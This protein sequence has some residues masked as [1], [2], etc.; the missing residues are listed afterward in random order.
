MFAFMVYGIGG[1][2]REGYRCMLKTWTGQTE[3]KNDDT[4][5]FAARI[6]TLGV[7]DKDS[8]VTVKGAFAN[9]NTVR[10]S[11]FNHSSAVRDDLPVGVATIREEG[12]A[13]IAEGK[14]NLQSAGGRELYDTLKFEQQHNV[15]SEWS[16]GFT[17]L[18]AESEQRDD[19]KVRVLKK[20]NPFEV[21]PVMRGAG[22]G[23]ATLAVKEEKTATDF[24]DLPL[25]DR[26][27]RWNSGAALKRVRQW[28]SKDGSGD[29][30]AM[31][32]EKY[33]KAFFWY[34]PEDDSSFGGFKLPFA[35]IT[36]GK[37]YA[38]PRG[39]F[40]VAGVLQG[41]RGG[42][43]ISP[44]DQDHV[45]DTVDRYYE[46]MRKEFDDDSIMVPWSKQAEGLSLK[47][48]G[49]LALT[50]IDSLQTRINQ[51]A[52]LRVKE[53][54]TLSS[55]NRKRLGSL[56]QS[57]VGVVDDLSDLLAATETPQEQMLGALADVAAFQAAL[58]QYGQE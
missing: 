53:G 33:K 31:D 40:A 13:V 58:A 37:L 1:A 51:L 30:D 45:K 47:H 21:S 28:A 15:Q 5:T 7:V 22:E 55:A 26:D 25:Y 41:S 19:Q 3:L 43:Q 4:G 6:A 2:L 9:A 56:V 23:T 52:D 17:V 12:D 20:L 36:D 42:V 14:L 34:D 48:E 16:Y 38:V 32:W 29:K 39:V 49:D 46:K 35:D 44:E 57:M 11:R 54:R 8:D 50:A 18:E 10:V 24:A 27:Y